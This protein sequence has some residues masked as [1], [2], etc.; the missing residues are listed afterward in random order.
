MQVCRS[1]T[2]FTQEKSESTNSNENCNEENVQSS[3]KRQTQSTLNVVVT[4]DETIEVQI[5]WV[6][7]FCTSC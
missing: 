5:R 2:K 4:K 3:S 1:I 7:I 6:I